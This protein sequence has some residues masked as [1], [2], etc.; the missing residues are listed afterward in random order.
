MVVPPKHPKMI[1]FS[2]KTHGCWVPP[3]FRTP[4]H[5]KSHLGEDDTCSRGELPS[6]WVGHK[7]QGRKDP[8]FANC[9]LL[10]LSVLNTNPEHPQRFVHECHLVAQKHNHVPTNHIIQLIFMMIQ[11]MEEILHHL[12]CKNPENNGGFSISTGAGFLPSTVSIWNLFGRFW[13]SDPP[14]ELVQKWHH[15]IQTC[16]FV[17]QVIL[18]LHPYF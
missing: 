7:S 11:L 9:W 3:Y 4:P 1:I 2:R 10:V 12:G 5:T 18:H 8:E 6:T 15:F 16:V 17:G 13:P 14:L